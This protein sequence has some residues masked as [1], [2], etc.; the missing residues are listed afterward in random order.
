[1]PSLIMIKVTK[2]LVSSQ[3]LVKYINFITLP[4]NHDISI[5]F[6]LLKHFQIIVFFKFKLLQSEKKPIV[7]FLS[8]LT[9]VFYDSIYWHRE[10]A[11]DNIYVKIYI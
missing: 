2:N 11:P 3:M 6:I 7:N 5:C 4:K 9:L 10:F 1:M 8:Y